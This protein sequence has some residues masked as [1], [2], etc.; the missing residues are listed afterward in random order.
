[1]KHH[2]SK[3]SKM[4][5]AISSI[6]LLMIIL[7][8]LFAQYTI[9]EYEIISQETENLYA[10]KIISS[11]D[12]TLKSYIN[13]YSQELEFLLRQSYFCEEEK[14]ILDEGTPNDL[15]EFFQKNMIYKDLPYTSMIAI[16]NDTIILS[17]DLSKGQILPGDIIT[18]INRN[19]CICAGKAGN[20]YLSFCKRS[21]NGVVYGLFIELDDFF[22]ETLGEYDQ[23][24]Y[25]EISLYD[26]NNGYFAYQEGNATYAIKE[27]SEK[28]GEAHGLNYI[29]QAY[30]TGTISSSFYQNS[31]YISGESYRARIHSI[32]APLTNNG[33]L[34]I[35]VS[36]NYDVLS[37]PLHKVIQQT[38]YA[39]IFVTVFLLIC[40]FALFLILRKHNETLLQI[41]AL[42]EKN[43][44]LSL[45]H[46]QMNTNLHH[47]RLE[48]IGTLTSGIAH[49]FN[50]LLTPIM[51]Y[52]I[53]AIDK[54][55]SEDSHDILQDYLTQIYD[56]ASRAKTL[57]RRI[58]DLSRKNSD[59]TMK[60]SLFD[61]M[62]KKGIETA[63]AAK[64]T[65]IQV[66]I[67]LQAKD[68][69]ITAN[70]LQISQMV[71]NLVLNAVQALQHIP[72][73][74]ITI[75][76]YFKENKVFLSISDNGPGI[77]P[78]DHAK[79][80]EPF[81]TTKETGKGTGLGLAIVQQ[82]V[83]EHSGTI[84]L[85]NSPER[86]ASFLIAFPAQITVSSE[87]LE[88]QL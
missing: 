40:I 69:S 55:D 33:R 73:G 66:K 15:L 31:G 19:G 4:I 42:K 81:Y 10:E 83:E 60:P 70:A 28:I 34:S 3:T 84:E 14:R 24:E 2:L 22:R 76:S 79:V 5:I 48:T 71:L 17:Y 54:I 39:S 26:A 47:Q 65:N 53:M 1:M 57:I 85:Q 63:L 43:H 51:G 16:D 6:T 67:Q 88:D 64:P 61:P 23:S 27:N 9:K 25:Y 8:I 36:I 78:E 13:R 44:E 46:E 74:M 62:V 59:L 77:A 29:K 35:A 20:A 11:S 37:A 80:F 49:E 86:G 75:H 68:V 7:Y 58:S 41:N 30:D 52:S 82:I 72:D 38:I 32:P 50:N 18:T 45:L 21:E 12:R 56:S 87:A